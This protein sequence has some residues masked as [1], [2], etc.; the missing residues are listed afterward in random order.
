L[1]P[2]S[3]RQKHYYK[4]GTNISVTTAYMR[5]VEVNVFDVQYRLLKTSDVSSPFTLNGV[6]YKIPYAD[7]TNGINIVMSG[8]HLVFSTT[9]GLTV[10]WYNDEYAAYDVSL[11]DAYAN[12]VCGLCGNADGNPNNDLVD[13]NNKAVP[14]TV[15]YYSKYFDW[16]SAWRVYDDS[17][18][19]DQSM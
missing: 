5:Y 8:N 12:Y 2:F 17:Y 3:V 16:A 4:A 11:C 10:Q 14:S 13:R 1:V 7:Q 9:F 15:G 19:C 18:D 6:S